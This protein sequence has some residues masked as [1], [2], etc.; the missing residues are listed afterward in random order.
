MRRLRRM[1]WGVGGLISL[2]ADSLDLL[3]AKYKP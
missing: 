1:R 3:I 2:L